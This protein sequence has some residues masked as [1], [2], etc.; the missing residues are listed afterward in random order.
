M[1]RRN[2]LTGLGG[3]AIG[4]G[5]LFGTGAFTSVEA[6]RTVEVNVVTPDDLADISQGND[7]AAIAEEYVDVRVDV[8]KFDTVY[9][10]DASTPADGT[11]F[12]PEDDSSQVGS[13]SEVSLIAND[14]PTI[15]FG[16]SNSGL[17]QNS[18]VKYDGLFKLDN[19]NIA[20]SSSNTAYDLSLSLDASGGAGGNDFLDINRDDSQ[21]EIATREGFNSGTD[22]G[23]VE[24]LD[25]AVNTA[26]A[27]EA[28]TL[29]ITIE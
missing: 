13:G 16:S 2:V 28:L 15:I 19:A 7:A 12:A 24:S 22:N 21:N 1:N 26:A 10:N 8:G 25:S 3:L 17:P 4:G 5:A 18:T 29:T 27:D 6:Q 9:V 14:D 20:G 11:G 23:G